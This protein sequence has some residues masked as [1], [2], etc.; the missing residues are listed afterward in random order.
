[1]KLASVE[2][3]FKNTVAEASRVF[4]RISRKE[5]IQAD[6]DF[7]VYNI[8]TMVFGDGEEEKRRAIYDLVHKLDEQ[9]VRGDPL[10]GEGQLQGLAAIASRHNGVAGAQQVYRG[11]KDREKVIERLRMTPSAEHLRFCPAETCIEG[12]IPGPTIHVF[13]E[14]LLVTWRQLMPA[15]YIPLGEERDLQV[16]PPTFP[17]PRETLCDDDSALQRGVIALYGTLTAS[18]PGAVWTYT[19]EEAP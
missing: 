2:S 19:A 10:K 3:L 14:P 12:Y 17:A 9:I 6:E 5:M 1:M 16:A 4:A 7:A 13:W 8:L 15:V 11:S 18:E